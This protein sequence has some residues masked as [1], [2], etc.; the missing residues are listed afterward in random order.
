MRAA[1][2]VCALALISACAAPLPDIAPGQT[3]L[4]EAERDERGIWAE[5]EQAEG[6]LVTSGALVEDE[7]LQA[8][9]R[10]VACRVAGDY[11]SDIRVYV[12]ER[13]GFNASMAPNGFMTVW[14][15]LLLRVENEAQLA[16]VLGHEVAHYQRRHTL[17]RWRTTRAATSAVTFLSIAAAVGGYGGAGS[18]VRLGTLLALLGYS[19][20]QEREADSLGFERLAAAGYDAGA[21]AAVW[22]NALAEQDAMDENQAPP[23]LLSTH[24]ASDDRLAEL[25]ALADDDGSG[26]RF[27]ERFNEAVAPHRSDWIAAEIGAGRHGAMEVV[28]ERLGESGTT[29][30]WRGEL[31]RR[32][33]EHEQALAAYRKATSDSGAPA[34]AHRGLGLALWSLGRETEARRAFTRYLVAAP[35]AEDT[36]MIRAY[37]EDLK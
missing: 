17:E 11:C 22:R 27:A 28:L 25:T 26:E 9:V 8:Y 34:A 10:D 30:Y 14:T 16:A 13:A 33:G 29:H 6:E 15:G 35:Q 2:A 31:L 20:E 19:R 24:P 4:A 1:A 7:A 3:N 36:A 23:L 18:L 12:V 32:D 5:M 37:I 21:A